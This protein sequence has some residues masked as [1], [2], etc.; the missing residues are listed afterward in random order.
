MRKDSRHPRSQKSFCYSN[1]R[2]CASGTCFVRFLEKVGLPTTATTWMLSRAARGTYRRWRLPAGTVVKVGCILAVIFVGLTSPLAH[3]ENL[4]TTMPAAGGI[5][6]FFAAMVAA[7]WAYDGWNNLAMISSEIKNP[8]RNLPLS[9]IFGTLAVVAIYL[10]TNVAYFLVLNAGEVGAS[11]RVAAAMMRRVAG[12][13]GAAAVSVAAMISIFAALN[14]SILTGRRVPYAMARDGLFFR[15]VG[16]VHPQYYTPASSIVLLGSWS[17][18]LVLSGRYEQLFTYVIFSSWILYG[19]ATASVIVLRRKRPHLERSYRTLGY[20]VV[21]F[22]FVLVAVGLL[23]STLQGS[24]RES[25]MGIGI[26][27]L[28]LPFYFYWKKRLLV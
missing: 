20:P 12:E 28:G 8:K 5:A 13:G 24:P 6:G 19:M 4:A 11:D 22:L 26:I 18:F 2:I 1:S 15:A 14:G 21:P 25:L 7:L 9:L 27:I 16:H 17:A 10:L 23:V 3:R